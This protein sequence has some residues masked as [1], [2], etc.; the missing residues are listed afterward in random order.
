VL[1]ERN[2][3]TSSTSGDIPQELELVFVKKID[4][5]PGADC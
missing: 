3:R 2:R 5:V 4:E 1:P